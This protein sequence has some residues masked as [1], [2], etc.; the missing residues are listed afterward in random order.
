MN[1]SVTRHRGR[2]T[3][4]ISGDRHADTGWGQMGRQDV[5]DSPG[6]SEGSAARTGM[7]AFPSLISLLSRRKRA[8][9]FQKKLLVNGPGAGSAQ[10]HALEQA[11]RGWGVRRR[12]GCGACGRG[13]HRA[14]PAPPSDADVT[15]FPRR[16]LPPPRRCRRS[17]RRAGRVTGS[18]GRG[19]GREVTAATRG[20]WL[21]TLAS[22]RRRR[23]GPP[24][25]PRRTRR[26]P[27]W[28]S[29]RAR[30]R[31]SRMTP[32]SGHLLAARWPLRSRDSRAGVSQR[33]GLE[34]GSEAGTGGRRPRL[35]QTRPGFLQ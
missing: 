22:S 28:P 1:T 14:S 11:R 26:P 23:A 16:L 8:V 33:S 31:A 15:T 30:L 6:P 17:D 5:T 12:G 34:P 19:R 20:R 13:D 24:R 4:L 9:V 3:I 18:A 7:Q 25:P 27:F 10:H 32:V 29:R 35:G 21:R 2:G